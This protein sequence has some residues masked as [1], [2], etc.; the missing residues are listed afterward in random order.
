MSQFQFSPSGEN[1]D[2]K[3]WSS[4]NRRLGI[5]YIRQICNLLVKVESIFRLLIKV[6]FQEY[7]K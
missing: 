5:R 7:E 3:M 4:D 6:A 2:Q 1:Y